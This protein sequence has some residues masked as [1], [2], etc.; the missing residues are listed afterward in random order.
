MKINTHAIACQLIESWDSKIL[1]VKPLMT[2]QWCRNHSKRRFKRYIEYTLTTRSHLI[3]NTPRFDEVQKNSQFSIMT[4][5]WRHNHSKIIFKW[6]IRNVQGIRSR[7]I[8]NTTMFDNGQKKSK[9][10]HYDVTMTSLEQNAQQCQSG[11]K[12]FWTPDIM[13]YQNQQ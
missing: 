12:R 9:F 3:P 13:G 7:L 11:T 5:L 6:Y 1:A 4:S 8:P 10:F 2:S